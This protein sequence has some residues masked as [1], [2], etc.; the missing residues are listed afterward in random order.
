MEKK[1]V[2]FLISLLLIMGF[3]GCLI[4]LVPVK[5]HIDSTTHKEYIDLSYFQ[6]VE[7]DGEIVN[8]TE[9]EMA[10]P[11]SNWN[12]THFEANFTDITLSEELI[13]IE[14]NP[15][16]FYTIQKLQPLLAVQMNITEPTIIYSVDIYSDVVEPSINPMYIQIN[17]YDIPT[18]KPNNTVIY[19]PVEL[20]ISSDPGWY[21]QMFSNPS[22]LNPGYYSLVIDGSGIGN[23]PQP[24]YRWFNNIENATN[25]DLLIWTNNGF[26]WSSGIQNQTFLHKFIQT[27]TEVINPEDLD[28]QLDLNGDSYSISNGI[29]PGTGNITI[30]NINF[31][32]LNSILSIPIRTNRT[33]ELSFNCSYYLKLKNR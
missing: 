5:A 4:N 1:R 15:T 21:R 27:T 22:T 25:P 20:N 6:F 31:N 10:L 13:S 24:L 28:M 33:V 23:A 18:Q 19:D 8:A 3:F 30:T 32:I 29:S 14:D 2:R 9:I 12:L 16:D 26:S 17:G 11:S 7:T